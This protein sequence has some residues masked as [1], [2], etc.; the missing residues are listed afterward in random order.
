MLTT[1]TP[2]YVTERIAAETE[3]IANLTIAA[4]SSE[5]WATYRAALPVRDASRGFH[6]KIGAQVSADPEDGC[7]LTLMVCA[8][9]IAATCATLPMSPCPDQA[10][11]YFDF[12][13]IVRDPDPNGMPTDEAAIMFADNYVRLA[14]TEISNTIVAATLGADPDDAARA[15]ALA[16]IDLW[17]SANTV[18]TVVEFAALDLPLS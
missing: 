4:Y 10:A 16:V 18:T 2:A 7:H 11:I 15:G 13:A 5:E 12:D 6:L 14:A 8:E 1:M 9:R 3:G 17:P